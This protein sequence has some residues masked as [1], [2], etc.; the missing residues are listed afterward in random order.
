MSRQA[1]TLTLLGVAFLAVL[2]LLPAWFPRTH[3]LGGWHW[4]ALVFAAVEGVL[5]VFGSIWLLSIAQRRLAR[6]LPH[7]FALALRPVPVP[8]EVKALAVGAASV[9][10][11]FTLSWLLG[12]RVPVLRRVI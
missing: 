4:Q 3:L 8:A 11:S 12:A 7:G 5:T 1:R 2:T 6:P 10:G 9:V